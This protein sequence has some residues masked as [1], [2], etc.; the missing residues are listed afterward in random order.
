MDRVSE[1][2]TSL[3]GLTE[4]DIAP[5][6]GKIVRE[7]VSSVRVDTKRPR[8][9]HYGYSGDK[10][11]ATFSYTA[12]SGRT[13]EA[14]VF[15]KW[16]AEPGDREGIHYIRLK[17]H[18]APVPELYGSLITPDDREMIFVELLDPV[19]DLAPF[20]RFVMD[21]DRFP[22]FL[23]T[24]AQLNAIQPSEDYARE[25]KIRPEPTGRD[26]MGHVEEILG[27]IWEGSLSQKLGASLHGFFRANPD[28]PQRLTSLAAEQVE[29]VNCMEYGLIHGD[30]DPDS[31]G[32]RKGTGEML[33]VDLESISFGRRFEDVAALIAAPEDLYP[34][35]L[36]QRDLAEVY[37]E[38]YVRSGGSAVPLEAFLEET[39]ALWI[40]KT[41][42]MLWW[43]LARALDG[44]VDWTDSRG[45][46]RR[47]C[48]SELHRQLRALLAET[49]DR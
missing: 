25:L 9:V 18:G 27:R 39:H 4:P 32:F 35:C 37:L 7:P 3:F 31:T 36:S 24:A 2:N 21:G 33:L 13:G 17:E 16:L 15:V 47:V 12:Q 22:Q 1:S 34:R 5:I 41:F 44:L 14:A 45:E 28:A 48:R 10:V 19:D 49:G 43:M 8:V 26:W 11:I 46:G 30:Y 23:R 38:E 6:V 42:S 29:P 40:Y 20:D